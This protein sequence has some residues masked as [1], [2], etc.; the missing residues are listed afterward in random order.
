MTRVPKRRLVTGAL[1]LLF[2]ITG[3]IAWAAAVQRPPEADLLL[4]NVRVFDP[5]AGG[6]T[7][8]RDILIQGRLIGAIGD[9]D[10]PG[11]DVARLDADGRYALLGLWDS[12]VHLSLLKLG[13]D[14][15]V[16]AT[17]EAFVRNGITSVRDVGGP[18]DTIAGLSRRVAVG[19][20]LGPRIYYAGPLLSRA[21]LD[22]DFT[23]MNAALPGLAVVVES[24]AEV[25]SILDRLVLEGATMTKAI[26]RWDPGLLR[27]YAN[28][29]RERSL[30]VVWDPG[31]PI[32]N[33]I[34]IDTALAVGVGS[35]EHAKAPWSGVLREDLQREVDAFMTPGVDYAAGEELLLRIMSLGESSVAPKRL[36]ALA[37]RWARTGTYFCPTLR[38][39]ESNLAGDPPEKMRRP[40]EG[41]LAVGRLFVRDLSAHGV[42]VLVGQDQVEPD[43]TLKEM[44]A[45]A[46]AGVSPLEILR[47]ATLY[48]AQW[49][50][51]E[52]RSG[53]LDQGKRADI[54]ILEANPLER[55]EN[56]RSWWRVVYAGQVLSAGGGQ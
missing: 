3:P 50:G 22:P 45:L 54:L 40:F 31:L 41:L 38:Q 55:I 28:A 24:A 42:K 34:P 20:V 4:Q 14:S 30:R 13:G 26:D 8:P 27:H 10:P 17:L 53:T 16:H 39:A 6:F 47:E 35:I 12:H 23:Q 1:G 9:L 56:I 7:N 25:D 18:L 37:E 33:P 52:D 36:A 19:Q 32:L 29:A 11:D 5:V 48:P 43:G 51:V 44:E 49:L 46:R 21:P 15:I 2:M